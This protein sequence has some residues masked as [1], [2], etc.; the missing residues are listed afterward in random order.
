MLGYIESNHR[1]ADLFP[2]LPV[3][4]GF[5]LDSGAI[6]QHQI[7]RIPFNAHVPRINAQCPPNQEF[8]EHAT[9]GIADQIR[10]GLTPEVQDIRHVP[11][12]VVDEPL[13]AVEKPNTAWSFH[14]LRLPRLRHGRGSGC[15]PCVA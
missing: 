2:R 8:C 13:G 1:R 15:W 12:L 9:E 10:T 4:R 11:T 14:A 5:D 7:P 6:G 3:R